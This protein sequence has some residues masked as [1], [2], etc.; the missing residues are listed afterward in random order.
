MEPV[1][2]LLAT[3]VVSMVGALAPAI[4][5]SGQTA[6]SQPPPPAGAGLGIRLAEAP[7]DR[8]RDPRAQ[9]YIV[10]HVRPGA[11][12]ERRIAVTNGTGHATKVRLYGGGATIAGGS[13]TPDDD[14]EVAAWITTEPAELDLPEGGSTDVQATIRVPARAT[15]G[16]R[17][18][19]VW[20]ELP[21]VENPNGVTE[22]SRVGVR[23]YLSVGEG[24]EPKSDFT[25]E[26][27]TAGRAQDGAPT[28]S[29]TVRNTGGR[30]LD[31]AGELKLEDG[32]GGLTAGPFPAKVGTTLGVGQT[33]PVQVVMDKRFPAGPWNARLSLRS[34]TTAREATATITFPDAPGASARPVEATEVEAKKRVLL[35]V[36]AVL[37]LV[38]V[39]AVVFT[40]L[41][42]R[43]L[44]ARRPGELAPPERSDQAA[45]TNR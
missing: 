33:A 14:G 35:P 37:L 4:G 17:Y 44:R 18:G 11:V 8:A 15:S 13:F 28:V 26:S 9:Q 36:A 5:A 32:P 10:D 40:L 22:V 2:R 39:A 24:G 41:Q 1:R 45:G 3:L 34:G 42:Q 43:A 21:G 12:I 6:T 25:I 23:I 38:A 7:A 30:A 20:A 27:L 16:E 19:V 31:M 29:A